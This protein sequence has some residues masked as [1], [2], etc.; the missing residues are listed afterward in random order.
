M[1]V[2]TA[3]LFDFI[4]QLHFTAERIPLIMKCKHHSKTET[5]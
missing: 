3:F 5:I 4:M 1:S 2:H